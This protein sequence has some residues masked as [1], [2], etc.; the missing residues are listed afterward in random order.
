MQ[1]QAVLFDLDGTLIDSLED[2]ADSANEMLA[3]YGYPAHPL[4]SYRM[5]VGDGMRALALRCLPENC[6]SERADE[7][8]ERFTAIYQRRLC[9]KTRHYEGVPELLGA[10]KKRGVQLAVCTNKLHAAANA[11]V[12]KLFAP[13]LFSYVHG[14]RAGVR[15]K[16]DP[17]AALDIAGRMNVAPARAVFI[18]DSM[19]DMQT[20]VNAGM[21][22]AGV[23]WGFRDRAELEAHGA[24]IVLSKPL[25]LLDKVEFAAPK[26]R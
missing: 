9:N 19:T 7:A 22:P 10:L 13:N 2:L 12:E 24:R 23:L 25:E 8:L 4:A 6:A 20:A 16:P 26:K 11:L 17:A 1:Y 5:M 14:E 18:G 21:F 15:R 3:S